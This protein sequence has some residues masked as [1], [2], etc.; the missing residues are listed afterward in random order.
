MAVKLLLRA[1]KACRRGKHQVVTLCTDLLLAAGKELKKAIHCLFNKSWQE[2]KCPN[3][4]KVASV[5]FLKK[6]GK[7]DYHQPS[8]YRSISLTSCLG[9]CTAKI[10][11][12]QLYG[13]VQHHNLLDKE[14]EGFRNF[15]GTSQAL[16]RII[17]DIMNGFNRR[18]STLALTVDI[19]K[20]H[21]LVWRDGLLYRQETDTGPDLVLAE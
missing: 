9:K 10:I 6:S 2:G 8:A 4:W 21:D 19:E 7:A 14:K 16:L 11:V 20:A 15:T 12:T 18:D 3:E 1:L 5:T 17:Q 13:Y